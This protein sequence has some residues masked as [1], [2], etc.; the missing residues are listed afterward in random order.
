MSITNLLSAIGIGPFSARTEHRFVFE[1]ERYRIRRPTVV[2]YG[3]PRSGSTLI[4]Q[5]LC[6]LFPDR[7]VIKAH[8]Y[9]YAEKLTQVVMCRRDLR[10]V[11][12]S[13][14]RVAQDLAGKRFVEKQVGAVVVE[15][16]PKNTTLRPMTD[17][18]VRFGAQ[19]IVRQIEGPYRRYL[20]VEPGSVLK[21]GYEDFFENF[22]YL[23][24]KFEQF[25][26]ID[27][28]PDTRARVE[29]ACN[30]KANRARASQLKGFTEF[31]PKTQIHGG[32]IHSG[33]IGFWKGFLTPAQVAI[34][35]DILGP[36]LEMLEY[37]V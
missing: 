4:Y 15:R 21:V 1:N 12:I 8:H 10:D 17:D 35:N 24:S 2:A 14:W 25:F 34:A 28:D 36:V 27:I 37:E 5:V 16:G 29:Q 6:Q 23:F 32:H 9:L 20:D 31:D 33:E 3:I 11:M 22:P 7:S 30:L 18:E 26:G 19:E 13:Q